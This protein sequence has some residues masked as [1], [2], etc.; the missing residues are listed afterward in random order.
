MTLSFITYEQLTAHAKKRPVS[1]LFDL[2]KIITA[3]DERGV[4]YDT[5]LPAYQEMLRKYRPAPPRNGRGAVRRFRDPASPWQA[6]REE[7]GRWVADGW[8]RPGFFADP[9]AFDPLPGERLSTPA[10]PAAEFAAAASTEPV[11]VVIPLGHGSSHDDAEL[12]YAL[13]SIERHLENLGRVWIVGH[14]PAWLRGVEHLP[15]ED[16]GRIKDANILRKI[17]AACRAGVSE[18]FLRWSDDQVLLRPL[19]WSQFGP[20][21]FGDL[22]GKTAAK[23][24]QKRQLATR[25]WLAARGLPTW[26]CDTHTPIPMERAKFLELAAAGRDGWARGDGVTVGTWYCN[27][28][29]QPLPLGDRKATVEGA[30]PSPEVRAAIAGRWFLGHNDAG[31]TPALRALLDEL[32]PEPS[33]Y[34]REPA[35]R[36]KPASPTLSV[37]IPTIGRPTL[38]R[39]LDSIRG[40]EIVDGD[41]VLVVQDGP[42]DLAT[43]AMVKASGLP[44]RYLATGKR[45][46]DFGGTPRNHGMTEARGDY[47]AFMDDDD[48]YRP[49]AFDAIRAAA[50]RHPG[51]P[52]MFRMERPGWDSTLWASQIVRYANV[53]TPMFVVPNRSNQLG[54]WGCYRAADFGFIAST[55]ELWPPGSLIWE[56]FIL[57]TVRQQGSHPLGASCLR[58]NLLYHVYPP[59][60]NDEWRMN[61]D[62]LVQSW[63]LFSGR[64]I[65]GIVEDGATV[66]TDLVKHAFPPDPAIE[67]LVQPNDPARGETVTFV[68]GLRML[69]NWS[70]EELT[71]YAH[72]KGTSPQHQEGPIECIRRWRNFMYRH[73]LEVEAACLDGVMR[74][75]ACGG[76]LKVCKTYR[77][78]V[79]R[80]PSPWHFGGTFFWI[81]H[82]R[83]FGLPGALDL[84]PSRWAVERHLGEIVP[85][86]EAFCFA[87]DHM[88][89]VGTW[90]YKL[91]PGDWDRLEREASQPRT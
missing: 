83:F 61:I 38:K 13:R 17:E 74:R 76:S 9:P 40:Q 44:A 30:L 45:A 16:R 54:S 2:E 60:S 35:I 47:L 10:F 63:D 36:V 19:A 25:D 70:G 50:T 34:E 90:A 29:G 39:T 23:R 59:A 32:F 28:T 20:Y 67:W 46:A 71:F 81:H 8:L 79:G 22:A 24:W 49:G 52:L 69:R 26:H 86:N 7:E 43:W 51:R 72:A 82:A 57:A 33:R 11:D 1:Y 41:E 84:G 53:S 55:L 21:R 91:A 85:E 80:P 15:V 56:P 18:R 14:R 73:T 58:R 4:H 68:P 78:E 87:G 31:F 6:W 65:I 88:E 62:R 89:R 3:R 77:H 5:S 42:S 64:K 37:I 12:R 48:V 27:Q 75:Y 66:D